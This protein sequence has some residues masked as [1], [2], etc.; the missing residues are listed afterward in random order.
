MTFQTGSMH[1][2]GAAGSQFASAE[3]LPTHQKD[4]IARQTTTG[5]PSTVKGT[6]QLHRFFVVYVG[7]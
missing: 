2:R 4:C 6:A 3:E 7:N 5:D 1:D